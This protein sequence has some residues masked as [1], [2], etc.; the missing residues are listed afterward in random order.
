LCRRIGSGAYK[1]RA[2]GKNSAEDEDFS[3][4]EDSVADIKAQCLAQRGAVQPQHK[5]TDSGVCMLHYKA[6]AYL[7]PLIVGR[8]TLAGV[9]K[10]SHSNALEVVACSGPSYDDH[11]LVKKTFTKRHTVVQSD[12]DD[13]ED[14]ERAPP[15]PA[16]KA[17]KIHSKLLTLTRRRSNTRHHT[18]HLQ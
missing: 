10:A 4:Q 1:A 17:K 18:P 6:F 15:P 13:N 12:D 3:D 11:H 7:T 9:Q 14:D 8:P 2:L 5:I 16:P